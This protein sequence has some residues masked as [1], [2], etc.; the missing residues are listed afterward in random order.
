MLNQQQEKYTLEELT[1]LDFTLVGEGKHTNTICMH[2]DYL[3]KGYVFKIE[4]NYLVKQ[5]EYE[6]PVR[7]DKRK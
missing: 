2:N 5:R 6:I 3:G 4:G 7:Y 1:K